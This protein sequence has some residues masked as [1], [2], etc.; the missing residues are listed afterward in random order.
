MK[1]FS[2][3]F[4]FKSRHAGIS[5]LTTIAVLAGI[6]ILNVVAGSTDLKIDLTPKKLFSLTNQTQELL[7]GL[8]QEVVITALYTAGQENE[9]I[10][11]TLS[12]YESRSNLVTLNVVDPDRDPG[13]VARYTEEGTNLTKGS[14]IVSSGSEFRTIAP[15]E[16]YEVSYSQNGQPQLLGQKVEQMVTSA[17]AFVSSGDSPAIYEIIGH[18]EATLTTLG[19]SETLQQA[20][21]RLSEISLLRERIPEDAAILTLFAPQAD[22]SE[23]EIDQIDAF[24]TAG[25]SLFV[26]LHPQYPILPNL[27]A[28]LAKW[29]IVVRHGV[30]MENRTNRLIPEFGD[31]KFVFAPYASD[32][33]VMTP[34]K[35]AKLDPILQATLGFAPTPS[36]QRQLEYFPILSSSEDSWLR[37]NI[38][39]EQSG[40]LSKIAGDEM[41]P[42]DVVVGV[43]QR[44]LDTYE[45]EGGT[46][47]AIGG[48]SAFA[49]LG[50]L[51]QIKA[52]AD[53]L[54]GLINWTAG[55]QATILVPSKS[56]Y[57]LPLRIN[58]LTAFIYAGIAV[59]LIPLLCLAG[60]LTVYLRRRHK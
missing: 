51:G 25:G 31:S 58:T 16:L 59:I 10:M 49:S 46:I 52:N 19:Y 30:V 21:Y 29:D 5:A 53:L 14:L 36:R 47:V 32:H 48:A 55:D 7:D 17:L 50:Y 6:I 4:D 27:Y 2:L 41:G 38:D 24:L 40:S 23:A 3:R 22:L 33:E 44:N 11:E 43:R 26:A 45:P 9:G 34:L 54:T 39:S 12:E 13:T 15:Q 20:N 57:K 56:L 37:T 8:E 60:G 18:Q 42:I 1:K 28:L 35:E